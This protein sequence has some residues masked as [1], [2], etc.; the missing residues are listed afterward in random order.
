MSMMTSQILKFV[1]FTKIYDIADLEI[2][3]FHKNLDSWERN[4]IFFLQIKKGL[5][6]GE[7]C[8]CSGGNLWRDGKESWARYSSHLKDLWHKKITLSLRQ[9]RLWYLI[10]ISTY[11]YT[12][13]HSSEGM[14]R[15]EAFIFIR[16]N[17]CSKVLEANKKQVPLKSYFLKIRIES[18]SQNVRNREKVTWSGKI[19]ILTRNTDQKI[20]CAY[21]YLYLFFIYLFCQIQIFYIT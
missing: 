13:H 3:G 17:V 5:L 12:N 10:I 21:S 19:N 4:I 11:K 15:K 2:C 14:V 20:V 1:D 8:F 18:V 7:K 6:Y 16:K 9:W